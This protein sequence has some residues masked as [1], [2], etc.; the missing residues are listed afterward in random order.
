VWL[1]GQNPA[2]PLDK[3]VQLS[4]LGVNGVLK[5]TLYVGR[6][7]AR[8]LL[9]FLCIGVLGTTLAL[10][11]WPFHARRNGVTW[12]PERNGI[13]FGKDSTVVSSGPLRVS[14]PEN[15]VGASLEIGLQPIRIWD[16]GTLLAFYN[17]ENLSQ[18]S[19]R[20]DQKDLSVKISAKDV[21]QHHRAENLHVKDVFRRLPP[22][23]SSPTFITINSNGKG[24]SIYIEGALVAAE[25]HFP[26]SAKDFNGQLVV[27]DS[28]GQPDN[29]KGQLFGLAIYDRQLTQKE[30][31]QNYSRWRNGRL[32]LADDESCLALYLFDERK[33]N[34]VR[35]KA[36]SG[37]DLDIPEK[38]RVMEK[39]ALEPFWTEF[40]MTRSY[41]SA[42]FKNI[43][44]F[45][46]FGISFGAYFSVARPV[47]RA[48]LLTIASG[49]SVSLTIEIL[50][51]FLPN[52]DSGTSDLITNTL[53]TCIGALGYRLFMPFGASKF[54]RLS[55]LAP[56]GL[57][58]RG[59]HAAET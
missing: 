58:P 9:T 32:E 49:L 40:S 45:I 12:L 38:Y 21:H 48:M 47:R 2:S 10:G 24:V 55:S 16:S 22:S 50:Q 8:Y 1:Q 33:G 51:A 37:V 18:F 39:I 35:D 42:A 44:G 29:W 34:V 15:S 31:S 3:G 30:I 23:E 20:Q 19:L 56:L 53:G 6:A 57:K 7:G 17:P 4:P 11:L 52:R 25:P 5:A 13:R 26:L 28:P 36:R 54:P 46:P 27:G 43:V 41:W 14:N 59:D